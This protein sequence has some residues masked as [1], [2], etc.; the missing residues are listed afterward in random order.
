MDLVSNEGRKGDKDIKYAIIAEGAK[1]VCNT[2]LSLTANIFATAGI[3]V[4]GGTVGGDGNL[5]RNSSKRL[6]PTTAG[7]FIDNSSTTSSLPERQSTVNIVND[8]YRQ[9]TATI[10]HSLRKD[11]NL[12][13]TS[14]TIFIVHLPRRFFILH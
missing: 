7:N 9:L 1:I 14:S 11:D 3:E 4:N 5:Y 8:F 12:P 13:S 6:S 2:G 10:L